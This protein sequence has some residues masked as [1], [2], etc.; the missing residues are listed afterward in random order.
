MNIY[1]TEFWINENIMRPGGLALTEKL[2]SKLDFKGKILDVGSGEGITV[3]FLL[4]K[5]LSAEGTDVS[6]SLIERAEENVPQGIFSVTNGLILPY[7]DREFQAVISECTMS[8]VKYPIEVLKE[9]Y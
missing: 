9:M 7:E 5:G 8:A 3:S 2:I 6:E 1:E 4:S